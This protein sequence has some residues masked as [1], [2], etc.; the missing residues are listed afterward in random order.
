MIYFGHKTDQ[1][2][3]SIAYHNQLSKSVET[4]QHIEI[5]F[6]SFH[7]HFGWTS[8]LGSSS[9][10]YS[11]FQKWNFEN[12]FCVILLE[13]SNCWREGT[14]NDRFFEVLV[15][16]I[17]TYLAA[18]CRNRSENPTNRK[19]S[20][21]YIETILYYFFQLQKNILFFGVKNIFRKC[22]RSKIFLTPIF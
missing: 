17:C 18:E 1:F 22:F 15:S 13:F 10:H 20:I 4:L 21:F 7:R 5:K 6:V 8:T 16:H 2:L 19:L 11:T 12:V 9:E 14:K 3:L